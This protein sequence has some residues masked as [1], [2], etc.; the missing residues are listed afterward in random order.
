MRNLE[1][2]LR[3]CI[4]TASDARA[5]FTFA[6]GASS[7]ERRELTAVDGMHPAF[8]AFSRCVQEVAPGQFADQTFSFPYPNNLVWVQTAQ[9]EEVAYISSIPQRTRAP[10]GAVRAEASRKCA[11]VHPIRG[12]ILGHPVRRTKMRQ[13]TNRGDILD[14]Y[15]GRFSGGY[16]KL[17]RAQAL[18]SAS[19]EYLS[20]DSQLEMARQRT[21]NMP[22]NTHQGTSSSGTGSG[23]PAPAR[24]PRSFIA[25]VNCRRLKAKCV[26][27]EHPPRSACARCARRG[28]T[29]EYPMD[30]LSSYPYS[31]YAAGVYPAQD[32]IA[33]GHLPARPTTPG[34]ARL[35]YT[36]PPPPFTVPRY[37]NGDYPPL[38]S[39]EQ[40]EYN[41]YIGYQ[42]QYAE[43]YQNY[44]GQQQG[45]YYHGGS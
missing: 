31:E 32:T 10:V 4:Y 29:C 42:Q 18:F 6:T 24:A 20:Q 35:P 44:G 23:Q 27:S 21:R 16:L 39:E 13:P 14:Q 1:P 45:G 30:N 34:S 3:A 28:L 19:K 12:N 2:S 41:Q 38:G 36:G 25:C 8:D 43:Y 7:N 40:A 26:Q 22:S 11:A 33:S 17:R 37:S 15:S 5:V 9:A